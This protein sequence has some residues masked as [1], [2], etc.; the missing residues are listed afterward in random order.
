MLQDR[1]YKCFSE[2]KINKK[3]NIFH[4]LLFSQED[5]GSSDLTNKLE[6]KEKEV[7]S[8]QNSLKSAS[9]RIRHLQKEMREL[10]DNRQHQPLLGQMEEEHS[11]LR[12][13]LQQSQL[14]LDSKDRALKEAT[15]RLEFSSSRLGKMEKF[16][17][18]QQLRIIS[19]ENTLQETEKVNITFS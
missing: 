6:M 15:A 3:K 1:V 10:S 5:S 17:S 11:E 2:A 19:L 13:K 9:E 8:L 16:L 7:S 14:E 18:S 12:T 4:V